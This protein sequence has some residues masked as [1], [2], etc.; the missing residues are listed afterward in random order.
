MSSLFS[1]IDLSFAVSAAQ[2]S[3]WEF[4]IM[5]VLAFVVAI[6][7]GMF[8]LAMLMDCLKRDFHGQSKW[9]MIIL[10]FNIIGA[11]AYYFNVK[12]PDFSH[13]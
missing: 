11:L 5:V 8:C 7:L 6:V 4:A 12:R 10:F 9:L 13:D 3:A 1:P 2:L